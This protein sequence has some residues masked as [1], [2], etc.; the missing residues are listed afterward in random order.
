[1]QSPYAFNIL[2]YKSYSLFSE[3]LSAFSKLL[4]ITLLFAIIK[5]YLFLASA[6]KHGYTLKLLL[7][8]SA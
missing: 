8:F 5:N 2:L 4:L 7:T 1:M 3:I 6:A